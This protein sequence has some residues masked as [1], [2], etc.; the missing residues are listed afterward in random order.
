MLPPTLFYK[1]AARQPG[2]HALGKKAG[3]RSGRGPVLWGRGQ[4]QSSGSYLFSGEMFTEPASR[5][6]PHLRKALKA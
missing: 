4:D 3:R 2:L 1:H 5:I 6:A